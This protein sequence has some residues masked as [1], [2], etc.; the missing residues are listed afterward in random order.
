MELSEFG[1]YKFMRE[2]LYEAKKAQNI[3]EI[4]IG[5]VIVRDGEII[6]RGHNLREHSQDAVHHAEVMAIEEACLRTGS[7]R[8]ENTQLF[9]TLEPCAMCCGA[10]INSRIPEVYYGT[11]DPK[12]GCAGSLMN[13]LGDKRFNHQAQVE[14]GIMEEAS[15]KILRDF[16]RYIRKQQKVR[17]QQ[18]RLA[19][20]KKDKSILEK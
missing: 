9:V 8:L 11:K 1:K 19:Q 7:W 18:R 13:L 10:I 6:G 14:Y 17:K 4:P 5:C 15:A 16:F 2:A 20:Q 12:A 3:G